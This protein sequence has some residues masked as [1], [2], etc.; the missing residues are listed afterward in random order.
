[1]QPLDSRIKEVIDAILQ[2]EPS[3]SVTVFTDEG[4]FTI[5]RNRCSCPIMFFAAGDAGT[6]LTMRKNAVLFFAPEAVE[7][8]VRRSADFVIPGP[9]DTGMVQAFSRAISYMQQVEA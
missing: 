6:D 8:I 1:M 3:V 9:V 7:E 5:R 2:S 4:I